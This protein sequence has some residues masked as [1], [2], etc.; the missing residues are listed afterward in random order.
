MQAAAI[1]QRKT[2][3]LVGFNVRTIGLIPAGIRHRL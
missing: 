1:V 2:G 3:M